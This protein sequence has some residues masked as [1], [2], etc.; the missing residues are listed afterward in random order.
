MKHLINKIMEKGNSLETLLQLKNNQIKIL[1]EI[2][3]N[4]EG[5]ITIL[6]DSLQSHAKHIEDLI[7]IIDNLKMLVSSH[8]EGLEVKK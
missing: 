8:N 4:R 7:S 3:D 5:M 1:E 6:K 2:I